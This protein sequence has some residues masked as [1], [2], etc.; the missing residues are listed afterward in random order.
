[1]DHTRV[2]DDQGLIQAR[3]AG[4]GAGVEAGVGA[5]GSVGA[6]APLRRHRLDQRRARIRSAPHCRHR[7]HPRRPPSKK[8]GLYDASLGAAHSNG[9]TGA[10]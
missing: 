10:Q 2:A 1:V 5:G 9:V 3:A 4:A 7:R 8:M 6:S